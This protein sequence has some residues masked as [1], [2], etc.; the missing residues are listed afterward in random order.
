[1]ALPVRAQPR[2]APRPTPS[3]LTGPQAGSSRPPPDLLPLALH[4]L[5]AHRAAQRTGTPCTLRT[6]GPSGGAAPAEAGAPRGEGSGAVEGPG[7][8]VGPVR[9]VDNVGG[10][11]RGRGIV[12]TRDVAPGELLLVEPALEVVYDSELG[13]G[14]GLGEGS[15]RTQGEVA[16]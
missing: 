11:G 9:V 2:T 15:S 10:G 7:R 13:T 6:W 14:G 1:M 5:A 12:A 4:V 3:P 16:V 8:W